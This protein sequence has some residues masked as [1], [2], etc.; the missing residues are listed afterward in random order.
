M[1]FA[2]LMLVIA[3]CAVPALAGSPAS[4]LATY[5]ANAVSANP[6]LAEPAI[7]ALRAR[8]A[9]GLATLLDTHRTAIDA[10]RSGSTTPANWE[11]LRTAIDRVAG[12]RDA[13]ASELFWHTDLAAALAESRATGKPVLSLRLLGRLDEEL[14]CANSRFFRTALYANAGVSARMR[15]GFVLHWSSERPVPRIT[16][17][18]GDGRKIESTITGN[19]AHYVLDSKGR[20]VDVIPGLYGPAAFLSEL[21]T[22]GA[23]ARRVM[24]LDGSAWQQ[25]QMAYWHDRAVTAESEWD[26]MATT[27]GA[28]PAID[29]T[30][31]PDPVPARRSGRRATK[32]PQSDD[33]PSA[34]VAAVLVVGKRAVEAPIVREIDL[35][36][37]PDV[38]AAYDR[39]VSRMVPFVYDNCRL[40]AGGVAMLARHVEPGSD[41]ALVQ[42]TFEVSIASDTVLN[43]Y[44][45]HPMILGVLMEMAGSDF[46]AIN[47]T[48]YDTVFQ[49]PANDPWLGLKPVGVYTA[50]EPSGPAR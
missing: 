14:S 15:D 2:T 34:T 3:T 39:T 23:Q 25:A 47:R 26:A 29:P 33:P 18:F 36:P 1:R 44:R 27:A 4:P 6:S 28:L 19:S 37:L 22:T 35:A 32:K 30:P 43:R 49:T 50:I 12:Q 24:K 31:K 41:L 7:L 10:Y 13:Y 38:S 8:G 16:I 45:I 17:D 5:A 46:T 42:R 40:D 11:R 9:E 21:E 20:V 48:I